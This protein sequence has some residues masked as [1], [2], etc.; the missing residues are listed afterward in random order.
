MGKLGISKPAMYYYFPNK[1]ALFIACLDVFF[2]Q[3]GGTVIKMPSPNMTSREQITYLLK[4]FSKPISGGGIPDG[5]NHFYFVFDAIMHVPEVRGLYMESSM[6]MMKVMQ[7]IIEDGISKNQIRDDIDVEAFM[8]EIG[9][10][11][12]GFAVSYY[13]G[14]LDG[15]DSIIDRVI[16]IVWRGVE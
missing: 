3:I 5:F 12:E 9:V 13:M 4:N 16:D 6:G 7:S 2:R 11:L 1:K 10:L 15:D 14:Y 8:F